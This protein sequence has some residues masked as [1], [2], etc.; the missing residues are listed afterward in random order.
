MYLKRKHGRISSKGKTCKALPAV[1]S[2]CRSP[3]LAE[4]TIVPS[5]P[6]DRSQGAQ[7]ATMQEL[8]CYWGDGLRLAEGG[9]EVKCFAGIGN[10]YRRPGY[11]VYTRAPSV[12]ECHTAYNDA[13]LAGVDFFELLK[14]ITPL[15]QGRALVSNRLFKCY[16]VKSRSESSRVTW[17]NCPPVFAWRKTLTAC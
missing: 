13:R 9:S 12:S 15:I 7:L 3:R 2:S 14:V 8:V 16:H 17:P 10:E 4:W 11:S 5:A 1:R 6:F